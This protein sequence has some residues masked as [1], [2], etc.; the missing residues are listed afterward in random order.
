MPT[1][2]DIMER[3]RIMQTDTALN[4]QSIEKLEEG[5][6]LQWQVIEKIKESLTTVKMQISAFGVVN[7]LILAWIGYNL[8]KGIP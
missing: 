2:T 3:I 7:T 5:D 8:T 1:E 4:G 6:K